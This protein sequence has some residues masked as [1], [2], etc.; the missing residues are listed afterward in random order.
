[1][2]LL[3]LDAG[4]HQ[5]EHCLLRWPYLLRKCLYSVCDNDLY[6]LLFCNPE[7]GAPVDIVLKESDVCR[8]A[9]ESGS[10][11]FQELLLLSGHCLSFGVPKIVIFMI[12]FGIFVLTNDMMI[13][14]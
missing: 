10:E 4:H 11:E 8:S 5:L 7:Y 6:G 14:V 1:M 12:V 13:C 2:Q 9:P 3:C